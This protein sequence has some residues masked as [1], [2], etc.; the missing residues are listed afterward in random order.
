MILTV[1]KLWSAFSVYHDELDI[2]DR[3]KKEEENK[4]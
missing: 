3:G 1:E 4:Q 2:R